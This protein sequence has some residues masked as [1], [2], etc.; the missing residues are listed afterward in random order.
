[1]LPGSAEARTSVLL[2]FDED[3]DFPGL[4]LINRSLQDTFRTGLRGEVEF[5]SESLN[6]S[7]FKDPRHDDVLRE[8]F[9]RKY[10]G[11]H[12]DLVVAVMQ[13]SLDFLLRHRETL[14]R[15]VPLVFCGVDSSDVE[16]KTP[17]T[18]VTGVLVKRTFVP[19]L[20]IA[21]RLQPAARNI[22]VVGGT[23]P[24]DRQLQAIARRELS[25]LA[26]GRHVTYLTE[27]PMDDLLQTLSTL[28]ANSL[29]LYITLLADGA[30][31]AFI[32]HEALARIAERASAPVYVSV[33]QY[34]GRGAV[35]GHVYSVASHGR[36][37]AEIGLRLLRG[38]TAASI[39][40]VETA[41]SANMFDWRQ[42]QRWRLDETRL[43]VDSVVNFRTPSVWDLYRWHIVG[44]V[45]LLVMQSTLIVGLLVSRTKRR[46]ADRAMDESEKRRRRAEDEAQRGRDELAHA[47]RLTTL[48]ELTASFAHEI[49]QPL[50]SIITNAQA[51]RRLLVADRAAPHDVEDA[52]VD[53]SADARRA[54]ETIRRLRS[55]FRKEHVERAPVDVNEL[56]DDVLGL[57]RTTLQDKTILVH[58]TRGRELP[59]VLADSVQL[60]QVVLNLVVNAEDAIALAPDGPREIHIHTRLSADGHVAIAIRDSG[61][62]V[63]ESELERMFEHFVSSKPQGLGMGLAISRSI[64][65]A[66]A[67]RIWATRNTDRGLTLHIELPVRSDAS[68]EPSSA[69]R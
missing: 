60:R 66:H 24:F 54:A 20:E 55:L 5:Y 25:R 69:A 15:D 53:I 36:H 27:L 17:G 40:V 33:D 10:A 50:T 22:V 12:L 23:S 32:P 1:M 8:H 18:N 44:G 52:L 14:F 9:R 21:L 62:G 28:P 30:G 2:L 67:G 26:G 51:T 29:I 11:T 63:K 57:L 6:L 7:Q 45:A 13:P 16:G 42:L 41:A 39:P 35:G 31:Q 56:I 49:G 58:F 34:V 59:A 4:A 47:L 3:R 46:R 19:T 65:E 48:G 37:A 43:P 38:E 64:V 68:L 61:V